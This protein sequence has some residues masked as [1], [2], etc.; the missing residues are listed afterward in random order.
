MIWEFTDTM[1]RGPDGQTGPPQFIPA[2][3]Q[4]RVLRVAQT[5]VPCAGIVEAGEMGA[6]LQMDVLFHLPGVTSSTA[7]CRPPVRWRMT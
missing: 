3:T 5:D 2:N 1:A 7:S 6:A 4:E